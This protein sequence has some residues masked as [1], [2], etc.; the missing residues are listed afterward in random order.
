MGFTNGFGGAG[1]AAPTVQAFLLDWQQGNYAHAAALT[2]G[3]TGPVRA[4]LAAAYTDLDATNAFFAM[5][6]VTQHGDTAV[7]TYKATV[8]LAQAGQQWSY[9]GQF[10]LVSRDGRW[11]VDWAPSVVNP[12]LGAGD[13]L[14]VVTSYPQRAQI[15]D[16]DGQTLISKSADYQVGLYPGRLKNPVATAAFAAVTGLDE[17]QVLGQIQAAPPG[18][19]LPLLTLDPAGY[20]SLWPKLA[21]VPGL[22]HQQQAERLFSSSAQEV[23]GQ[24]G[25]ENSNELREEGAAYQPG[26]TVGLTGFEQMFQNDLIGTPTTSVVVVNAAGRNVATLWSSPGGHAGTP[27]R[28]TL[29]SKQQTAAM[30]ALAGQSNSA[31]IVALDVRTGAIRVLASHDGS[32]GTLPLGGTLA[33]RV[34]PGMAFSIVSAAALLSKGIGLKHPL[35]CVP[36]ANVGG[37]TFT[38]QPARAATA[39]LASDFADGCGTA[40]ANVSRTLTPQQL[41]AAERAFG[42]GASWHLPLSAFSGSA[43]A[44]SG[45]ADVAAQATGAGGV[46]MSPLGMATVA[47]EVAAGTGHSPML[48]PT[49]TVHHLEGAAV[50][51]AAHRAAAAD[52]PGRDLGVGGGG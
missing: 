4:Q 5:S 21:K 46:L 24:V 28:T 9:T 3:G 17:Q 47:A 19:F 42:I 8:D 20:G 33:A 22:S 38:Y 29:N 49:D 1:S 16:M 51:Q 7:A 41:T 48:I 15:E 50:R 36:V 35:P 32:H 25:T 31:E 39:T 11:L 6:G 30:T 43:P 23:V 10:K 44:V 52:A 14:A 27:V 26:M 37:E 2:N 18:A 12:Q 13:R 40:F 34:E 45:A